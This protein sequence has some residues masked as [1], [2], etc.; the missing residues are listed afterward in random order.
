MRR[1]KLT[2]K[3][4]LAAALVL[5]LCA[6]LLPMSVL[7]EDLTA[8][9][10][11]LEEVVGTV[12]L[13]SKSGQVKSYDKDK[14]PLRIYSGETVETGP[15]SYAALSLDGSKA[16]KL[17]A[18]SKARIC[19]VR[20]GGVDKL[21]VQLISG[22]TFGDVTEHVG[23][24]QQLAVTTGNSICGVVGTVFSAEVVSPLVTVLRVFRGAMDFTVQDVVSGDIVTDRITSGQAALGFTIPEGSK[25]TG[26]ESTGSESTGATGAGGS[27]T[28][29]SGT[30]DS[31]LNAQIV[32][33][34]MTNGDVV[35]N[36]GGDVNVKELI[37]SGGSSGFGEQASDGTKSGK[38][39]VAE[40]DVLKGTDGFDQVNLFDSSIGGT[41]QEDLGGAFRGTSLESAREQLKADERS[42]QQRGQEQSGWADEILKSIVGEEKFSELVGESNSAVT[43]GA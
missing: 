6:A 25:T 16:F 36:S 38:D 34:D 39:G 8:T 26:S 13:R 5:L 41:F 1:G 21:E 15:A 17:D 31:D 2:A 11:R 40:G 9:T 43:D 35:G 18:D 23:S 3:R 14:L 7:A 24:G 20:S 28:G 32:I 22:K 33:I 27:G 10:M 19:S 29:G 4:L 42:D 12:T 37:A 30:V